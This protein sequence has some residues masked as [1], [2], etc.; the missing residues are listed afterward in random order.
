MNSCIYKGQVNHQRYA[1][2]SHGFTYTLF[3]MY[4][5]LDELPN[6]F[7]RF[8]LW[9]VNKPNIASF[10]RKDHH[11]K[12][13][14]LADSIRTLVFEKTGDTI[15]GPIRLLTHL[16]YFGYI[17][18]P[19][20][21]YFCYDP[22]GNNITHVVAEVSNTPWKEQHCYVIKNT[23]NQNDITSAQKKEFH[24][25][26]F[27]NMDMQYQWFIQKPGQHMYIK[28]EN[29]ENKSKIFDASINLKQHEINAKNLRNILFIFPL[30]TL[31]ITT[32]IHFEAL[33]LWIK[34]VQ[35]V[36]HPKN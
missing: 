7:D 8:L 20:S 15:N 17:F 23:N 25:S 9:S 28:I 16:R 29:I 18:N 6:L 5:D 14:N 10:L 11:G 36:P 13:V 34:G 12:E 2:K 31:K 1:P 26:P 35:Y 30:I 19:I 24:V 27:L 4:L 21:V 22:S 32:L 3:M 33:K